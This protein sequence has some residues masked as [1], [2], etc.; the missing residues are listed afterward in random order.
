MIG[1]KSIIKGLALSLLPEKILQA[2]KKVHYARALRSL[3]ESDEA[4]FR[5]IR[6]LVHHGDHV[7][8]IGANIGV[9]TKFLSGLVG[10]KGH[11]YSIEPISLTF[12]ILL[13]NIRKLG[14]KNVKALNCAI[15][16]SDGSMTME[17]PLYES[18]GENFYQAKIVSKS[19][20]NPLRRTKVK[21]KTIDSLFSELPGSI[22]FIK[23]DVEG[24]EFRCIKGALDVIKNSKPAWLIETTGDPEDSKST[25]FETFR[26]LDKQ[27]YEAFW[28]DGTTLNKR[29][30][31]DKSVNYFFLA[32]RHLHAL[33]IAS[34]ESRRFSIKLLQ[35]KR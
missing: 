2:I 22:S 16:D 10:M 34:Y 31:G 8:D 23:C 15:S 1:I 13:Y 24:H 27:G 7:V 26:L 14:L 4:D 9:Y 6:H 32:P 29:R 3:S 18:G 20:N 33:L 28:F 17:V 25:A 35:D 11:V 19:V 5:V 12:D 30:I 21:S